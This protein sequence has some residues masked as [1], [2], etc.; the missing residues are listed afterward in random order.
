MMKS[1]FI[2]LVT[3]WIC[4][5]N[6]AIPYMP[7]FMGT[8]VGTTPF[9]PP[10]TAPFS[11][12]GPNGYQPGQVVVSA[13]DWW[14]R[15][16][17]PPGGAIG[18]NDFGHLHNE[19]CVYHQQQLP[20]NV[21]LVIGSLLHQAVSNITSVYF[22]D[23][24]T[25]IDNIAT[26]VFIKP[27]RASTASSNGGIVIDSTIVPNDPSLWTVR[28]NDSVS[29]SA[30]QFPY[31]G[32]YRV[33]TKISSQDP[34]RTMENTIRT[35]RATFSFNILVDDSN[36]KPA[37]KSAE[38]A[39]PGN[40]SI[41]AVGWSTLTNY[42]QATLY[43]PPK[44]AIFG[45]WRPKIAIIPGSNTSKP[46][47]RSIITWNPNFHKDNVGLVQMNNTGNFS[48]QV[49]M[50][51]HSILGANTNGWNKVIFQGKALSP[52]GATN[53]GSLA[54]NLQI[55]NGADCTRGAVQTHPYQDSYQS[56]KKSVSSSGTASYSI[57]YYNESSSDNYLT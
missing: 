21:P 13:E 26:A 6:A 48:G 23:R 35:Q 34:E 49:K 3:L 12:C 52:D 22:E 17:V 39:Y 14:R 51:V 54:F 7:P 29:Y 53:T 46:I 43:M 1:V 19:V 57:T 15:E 20:A 16:L 50:D 28:W 31:S 42:T 18:G 33:R 9:T 8:P 30:Y 56:L 24:I 37:N 41:T 38:P 10:A 4:S 27:R 32:L 40:N 5:T 25:E 44:Y 45:L 2:L 36:G 47:T 55:S 11:Y